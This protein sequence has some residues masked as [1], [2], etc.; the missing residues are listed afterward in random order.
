[1]R[2]RARDRL[3][4]LV[5][6]VLEDDLILADDALMAIEH[7]GEASE[8]DP[9]GAEA[10]AWLHCCS[11]DNAQMQLLLRRAAPLPPLFSG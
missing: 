3:A 10:V 6:V 8:V 4:D 5:V 9:L 2:V 11:S 7:I 1:M